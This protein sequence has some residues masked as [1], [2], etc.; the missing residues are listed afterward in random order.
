M[1][2]E[3]V[4]SRSGGT[5]AFLDVLNPSPF[6]FLRMTMRLISKYWMLLSY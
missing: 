1:L 2:N 5:M 6:F 4:L 3:L